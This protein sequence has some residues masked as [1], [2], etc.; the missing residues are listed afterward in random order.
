M[1][2][3][4]HLKGEISKSKKEDILLKKS[5]PKPFILFTEIIGWLQIF[6]SPFL[7]GLI[8]G[9]AVYF[10]LHNKTG[11]I[12]GSIIAGTGLIVGII[13][14]TRIWRKKGT[15]RFMSQIM[16]SPEF[17]NFNKDL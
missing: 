15:N 10:S 4:Q 16:S 7:I 13:W 9:G 8:I 1:I 11:I 6:A 5:A 3:K 14:A 2:S 12:I 17:D